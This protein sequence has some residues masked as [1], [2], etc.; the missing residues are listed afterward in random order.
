MGMARGEGSGAADFWHEE[1]EPQV[2]FLAAR[3][4]MG[5]RSSADRSGDAVI[6][7]L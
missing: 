5:E 3:G 6:S 7:L 1:G 4:E 2:C